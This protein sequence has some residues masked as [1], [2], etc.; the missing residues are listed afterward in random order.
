MKKPNILVIYPDQMRY[1][2]LGCNGN[3]VV[4]TPGLDRLSTE[5]VSFSNAYTSFPL[6]CP[7]RASLMTG[8]Y[9]TAHGMM[10][11]HYPISLNHEFLPS[12]MRDNG[13]R[14]GWVGKWHLNGGRK[15]DY[16]PQ[17]YRLG[18][19]HF[20][21]FSRGHEYLNPIYYRDDDT[22]PYKSDMFEPDIQ[23]CHLLEFIDDSLTDQVPFFAA[24]G[25]GVPH[26]SVDL[27]PDYYKYLYDPNE[28]SEST[29][30]SPNDS[31][32]AKE[33]M[34]KYYGLVTCVDYQVQQIM[35]HLQYKGILD[36]TVIILVS[37]HGELAY[38]HGL[39]GKKVFYNA[40]MHVPFII[41]YPSLCSPRCETQIVDPSVDIMPTILNLCGITIPEDV[42]GRSLETLLRDGCDSTLPD[43][44][45]YQIPIEKEGPE[46]HPEAE[47]G[48]R[49][50]SWLYVEVNAKPAYLFDLK[51]DPDEV[52]NLVNCPHVMGTQEKLSA[53]LRTTMQQYNDRWDMEVIFPPIDF[54]T[55]E[56]GIAYNK[57]I[58]SS[59]VY[60]NA[61][62]KRFHK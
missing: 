39:T 50:T 35:N 55:H 23:T 19:E 5:G 58:Y 61:P 16:V 49:T 32:A 62:K 21:G 46:K 40:S 18:F 27:S 30:V 45:F 48:I 56:E 60:E 57:I 51:N 54:Q 8:K 59:A 2:A 6:C 1:D 24:I 44:V 33:F 14:T 36:D 12:I 25:Y 3:T 15:H 52:Q 9:A 38:E 10:A 37:D 4:K 13:Y 34:A 41:R 7:F 22:T 31:E 47:R 28:I 42:E 20:V 26:P 43:Y 17:E 29:L 53:L 11:N